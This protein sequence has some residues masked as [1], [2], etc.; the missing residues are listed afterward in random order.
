M[1]Q[2][3]GAGAGDILLLARKAD[4]EATSACHGNVFSVVHR[5]VQSFNM[6]ASNE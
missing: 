4:D 2:H 5:R 6:L 3:A 1:G